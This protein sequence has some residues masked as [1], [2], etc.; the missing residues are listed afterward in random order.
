MPSYSMAKSFT[1]ALVGI[2]VRDGQ[3]EVDAPAAVPA[4][5][6]EGDPRRAITLDDLLRMSSGLAWDEPPYP[7]PGD[8]T[9]MIA[10][11]DAAAYVAAREL[12]YPPG[13]T[14]YYNS[15]NTILIDRIL[16]DV[17]GERAAFRQFMK[18]ELLDKLGINRLDMLFDP[19]GTWFGSFSADTTA[20]NYARF[21]LLYL[22]DG[23][24]DG[25]RILPEGWVEYSRTPS[26]ANPEYGAGWWLDL[27]QPGVF[28]AVGL[29]GQ[30]IT[31]DPAHDLTFVHLA[32]DSSLALPV[33][34]TILDAFAA[35]P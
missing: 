11:D 3:L 25:E 13:T 26:A 27:E 17:V 33:A 32:T 2:L 1:S 16:A 6:A 34:E 14:F 4:W 23:V 29:A 21:G 9:N 31:V 19:A 18:S 5:S 20:R 35:Q 30:V 28:Y 15:G 12:A 8:L 24:W 22:R 10:A 7:E